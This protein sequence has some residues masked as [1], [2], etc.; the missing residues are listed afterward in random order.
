M[1]AE[2]ALELCRASALVRLT[3]TDR[4]V[5]LL[6]GPARPA[7]AGGRG[8]D[9]PVGD[10]DDA[11]PVA[12]EVGHVTAA[13]AARL[14][15]HPTCLR[16][17]IAVQ[18]MLT[19]RHVPAAV[20]LGVRDARLGGAHAWVEVGGRVVVGGRRGEAFTTV[21]VFGDDDPGSR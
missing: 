9:R 8:S 6:R 13:V 15:W 19:R 16:Q 14:P 3:P 5:R 1:V 11:V 17:A 20:H 18:R 10:R 4:T 2:V 21:G 7:P 12:L